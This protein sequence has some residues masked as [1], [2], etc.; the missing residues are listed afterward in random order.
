VLSRE[1]KELSDL[2]VQRGVLSSQELA[3]AEEERLEHAPDLSLT[4]FLAGRGIGLGEQTQ[5]SETSAIP[6]RIG[7][8]DILREIGRGGMGIVFEAVQLSLGRRV[9]LKVRPQRDATDGLQARRF[10]REARAVAKLQHPNVVTVHGSG[11]YD[12]WQ[13]IAMDLVDGCSVDSIV[14][15]GPAGPERAAEIVRDIAEALEAAHHIGLVHRDVKP[16]NILIDRSGT[17]K[18]TDFGLVHDT[19]DARLTLGAT[20]LGTPAFMCPEQARGEDP[21]PEHDVYSLGAVLYTLV[22][23]RPP[24]E[25]KL[26]AAV[27]SDL[28]SRAPASLHEIRPEAPSALV[29][30]CERALNRDPSLRYASARDLAAD[31]SAFLRGKKTEAEVR[32]SRARRKKVSLCLGGLALALSLAGAGVWSAV[33]AN[34]VRLQ[35]G[36]EAG[37]APPP[38]RRITTTQG[39]EISPALSPEGLRV[40]YAG[41]ADGDWDIYLGETGTQRARNVTADSLGA[42]LDPAFSPS[43]KELAFRSEREGGG[44]FVLD[45][46]TGR[47]RK[48][49]DFGH[50]PSW[51]PSGNQLAISTERVLGVGR[52][53]RNLRSEIWIVDI[54]TGIRELLVDADAVEPAWSPSGKRIAFVGERSGVSGLWTVD[55]GTRQVKKC[56][57]SD[58]LVKD[59]TWLAGGSA[60]AFTSRMSG[61]SDIRAITIEE[62]SGSCSREQTPLVRSLAESQQFPSASRDGRSLALVSWK[63]SEAVVRVRISPSGMGVPS[64]VTRD[65]RVESAPDVSPDGKWLVISVQD[66]P[67][68]LVVLRTDDSDRWSLTQDIHEERTPRWSPDGEW[69]VFATNRT[70][71]F[72]IWRLRPSGSDAERLTETA[73]GSAHSPVWSPDGKRV[74]YCVSGTG[75]LEIDVE[76]SPRRKPRMIVPSNRLSDPDSV[77]RAWSLDG[78]FLLLVAREGGASVFDLQEEREILMPVA[79]QGGAWTDSGELLMTVGAEMVSVNP[80]TGASRVIASAAPRRFSAALAVDRQTGDVFSTVVENEADVWLMDLDAVAAGGTAG[81]RSRAR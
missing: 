42:D 60:L 11:S 77:P 7:E 21:T 20:V 12:G 59:P 36:G 39:L 68:D 31:L 62:S 67:S 57:A 3:A 73:G 32:R 80:R 41:D 30:I 71:N 40:A 15:Q 34:R 54:G 17:P 69:I 65:N 78:R 5:T 72:E 37:G 63:R 35:P 19:S 4:D 43:G 23:G 10:G 74:A 61:A 50:H 24:Y 16:S 46:D 28:L 76:A 6:S 1:D 14:E 58:G 8:F 18:L 2:L 38:L 51:S 56:V 27:L 44:V 9:A 45:L 55:V 47:A 26:P 49:V 22:S 13:Y 29:A 81:T 70:K 66:G 25:G 75:I 52:S 48:V 53:P 64:P 79:A 33:R